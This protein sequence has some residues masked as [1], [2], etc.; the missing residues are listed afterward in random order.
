MTQVIP[1]VH[2]GFPLPWYQA[3]V[4]RY[5]CIFKQSKNYVGTIGL[6][7]PGSR[8]AQWFSTRGAIRSISEPLIDYILQEKGEDAYS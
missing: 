4:A 2:Q 5:K 8:G 1:T 7:A 3:V 6:T